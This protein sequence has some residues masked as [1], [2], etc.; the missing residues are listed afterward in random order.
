M[1]IIILEMADWSPEKLRDCPS[2]MSN[3]YWGKDSSHLLVRM[4]LGA[5]QGV[6]E[7]VG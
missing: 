1:V 5:C 4:K 2:H 7:S 3:I 6:W